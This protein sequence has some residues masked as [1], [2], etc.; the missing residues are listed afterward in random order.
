M[1]DK[2]DLWLVG[3]A[4]RFR[5]DH[6]LSKALLAISRHEDSRGC[7]LLLDSVLETPK[8]AERL[9]Q[10]LRPRRDQEVSR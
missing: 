5:R 4:E 1:E 9:M 6:E 8:L 10:L 7:L 3:G 2:L